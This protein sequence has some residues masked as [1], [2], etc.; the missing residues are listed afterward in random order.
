MSEARVVKRKVAILLG[1]I[2][3]G[4]SMS[5]LGAIVH[6]SS[7][8]ETQEI[9]IRIKDDQIQTLANRNNQ[10]E[11]WLDK[12]ITLLNLTQYWLD[13]NITYYDSQIGLLNSEISGMRSQI[14]TLNAEIKT[15]QTLI[16]SL[17]QQLSSANYL[18]NDQQS[19][20]QSLTDQIMSLSSQIEA[21]TFQISSL[22]AQLNVFQS[23]GLHNP[24]YAE[25]LNFIDGDQTDQNTYTSSYNCVNFAADVV[26]HAYSAHIECGF[27]YVEFISSAHSIVCFNTVDHGVVYVEPQT[28]EVVSVAIGANYYNLGVVIKLVIAW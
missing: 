1:I 15:K 25:A 2:C 20:I 11:T 21:L 9:I 4:L 27:V 10:L 7:I 19:Q 5:L 14:Q 8:V 3:I 12:N 6:Y 28:D 23:V 13:A 26:N 18:I 24:T 17:Q 16:N 22:Q